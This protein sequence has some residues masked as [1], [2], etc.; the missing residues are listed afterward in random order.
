MSKEPVIGLRL[1]PEIAEALRKLAE[2]N[3]RDPFEQIVFLI[4]EA[5]L[6]FLPPSRADWHRLREQVIQRF[7]GL[8]Q[9]ITR[10]EGWRSDIIAETGGRLAKDPAW[11]ADYEKLIG[12]DAF[13]KSVKVKDSI[14]PTIGRRTKLR[15]RAET[16]K[17]FAVRQPSIFT[18]SSHLHQPSPQE[19]G[20]A[21]AA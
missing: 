15:L 5:V 4:T 10:T 18:S 14:N 16:G 19:S 2:D 13:A 11:R 1:E 17:V 7:V 9:E 3:G 8:A 6:P 12:A 20:V 21:S